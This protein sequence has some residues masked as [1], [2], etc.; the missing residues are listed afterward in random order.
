MN[1]PIWR[2]P[3]AAAIKP[4]AFRAALLKLS[5]LPSAVAMAFLKEPDTDPAILT[6]SWYSLLA[7]AN[8]FSRLLCY[9]DKFLNG[10]AQKEVYACP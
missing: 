4:A 8:D 7:L 3:H 6:A 10:Q 5:I 1:S 9:L 2:A